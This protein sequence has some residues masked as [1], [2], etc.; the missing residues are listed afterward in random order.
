MKIITSG[1]RKA[2]IA[3]AILTEGEGKVLINRRS[4]KTFQ[5]FDKLK[6]EEVLRI[7]ENIIGKRNFEVKINKGKSYIQG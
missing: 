2:A 6:I 5:E 1:K 7:T 4:Y 3:R